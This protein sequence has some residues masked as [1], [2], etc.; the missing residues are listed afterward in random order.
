MLVRLILQLSYISSENIPFSL[1]RKIIIELP[2]THRYE[3]KDFHLVGKSPLGLFRS[4]E[5]LWIYHGSANALSWG[6]DHFENG[7]KFERRN[8]YQ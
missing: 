7:S 3:Y 4:Q 2:M 6:E 8:D 5:I 1:G